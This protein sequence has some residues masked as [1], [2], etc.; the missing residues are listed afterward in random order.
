MIIISHGMIKSAS[1]FALQILLKI[2]HS[3][4]RNTGGILIDLRK[5]LPDSNG[6]YVGVEEDIDSICKGAL[7]DFNKKSNSFLILK[8]HNVCTPFVQSLIESNEVIVFSTFRNPIDIALSLC[9]AARIDV[10]KGRNRFNKY[11]TISDTISAIDWQIACFESWSKINGVELIYYDDLALGPANVGQRMADRLSIEWSPG[12]LSQFSHNK[13][14]IWE[15]N[16]GRIDRRFN[17][18]SHAELSKLNLYWD[19]FLKQID[20]IVKGNNNVIG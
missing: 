13:E 10:E 11:Q 7:R 2:V 8:T 5:Y 12:L 3:H 9:D 4:C 17:D 1:S 6:L 20:S 19:G 16:T 18:L 14:A 15:F